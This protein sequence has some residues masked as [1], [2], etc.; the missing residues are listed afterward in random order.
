MKKIVLV[1]GGH[2]HLEWILRYSRTPLPEASVTLVSPSENQ[3]YS[4]MIGGML[5]GIYP[6]QSIGI[7]LNEL[8][9]RAGIQFIQQTVTAIDP[10]DQRIRMNNGEWL[11]YDAASIDIGAAS[12]AVEVPGVKEY[13]IIG[14][15]A[16]QL[17]DVGEMLKTAAQPV[18]VG[19]GP[20]G[21]EVALALQARIRHFGLPAG[22]VTLLTSG[23]LMEREGRAISR[24]I[25][26][27]LSNKGIRFRE[28]A[29]VIEVDRDRIRLDTGESVPHATLVWLAGPAP[30]PLLASGNFRLSDSGYPLVRSTLQFVDVPNLFGAG[31]CIT[32]EHAPNLPKAGVYAVREADILWHN[33]RAYLQNRTL[34]P[35]RPP[36]MVLSILS[37]GGKEALLMYGRFH[38]HGKQAWRLKNWIDSRY[39]RRFVKSV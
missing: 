25:K 27:V 3:I 2:A 33:M 16:K 18:V 38:C 32:L 30:Q 36:S 39:M 7:P 1:G 13:A 9:R 15:P 24:E 5:E 34:I 21:V 17:L 31:D 12:L 29:N 10:D 26:K 14:R 4:G 35:F 11:S 6:K 37:T 28:K 22:H 20:A 8:S 19:G 23:G